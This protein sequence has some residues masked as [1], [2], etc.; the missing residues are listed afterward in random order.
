M[1]PE[2]FKKRIAEAAIA[3]YRQRK[4]TEKTSVI[5]SLTKDQS[6]NDLSISKVERHSVAKDAAT[7]SKK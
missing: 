2:E 5:V 1:T 4:K 3:R 6:A 7:D